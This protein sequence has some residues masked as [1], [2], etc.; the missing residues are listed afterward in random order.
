LPESF[1]NLDAYSEDW[2][3]IITLLGLGLVAGLDVLFKSGI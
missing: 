3:T 2:A 1:E